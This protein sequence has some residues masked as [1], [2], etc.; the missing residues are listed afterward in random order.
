MRFLRSICRIMAWALA[1]ATASAAPVK[2]IFDTDV[3]DDCDDAGALAMLHALAD[4]GEIELLA[5]MVSNRVPQAA[6]CADAINTWFGRPDLPLGQ[7]KTKESTQTN[8]RYARFI[9]ERFPHDVRN[10]AEVPDAVQ[11]YRRILAAQP[12]SSVV[13]VAV[14]P[15]T[16]ISDLLKSPPDAI[17]PLDGVAL[18]GR[19]VKFYSAGGNGRAGLPRG[20][21]GWNYKWD[22]AAARHELAAMPEHIPFVFAGGSGLKVQTGAGY[23]QKPADHIVR[24]CYVQFHG[25]ETN[26]GRNS[27]DQLRLW[28]AVRDRGNFD[29]TGPGDV[30]LEQDVLVYA[31]TPRRNRSYAYV[32]DLA[33]AARQIEE[34]MMHEPARAR[35]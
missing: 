14:G 23:A 15:P 35:D 26:L 4:R 27:W 3:G 9:A 29:T 1:L 25:R 10:P 19:K 30:R 34:L 13:I 20:E 21:A 12:D 17:S 6:A 16:N 7:V 8:D 28:Y 24:A 22:L 5:V 2:L 32:K 33:L 11:L 18:V 31:A